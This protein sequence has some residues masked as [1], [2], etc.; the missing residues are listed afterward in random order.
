MARMLEQQGIRLHIVQAIGG[1]VEA[2]YF[3]R[4]E[5]GFRRLGFD[6]MAVVNGQQ[7]EFRQRQTEDRGGHYRA[8][9]LRPPHRAQPD[10]RQRGRE[11]HVQPQ[12]PGSRRVEQGAAK[13][14]GPPRV[15]VGE[16]QH[17]RPRGGSLDRFAR[18]RKTWI[19]VAVGGQHT[20]K[21]VLSACR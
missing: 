8:L 3:C 11:L 7:A 17:A 2:C 1:R 14:G 10:F 20:V 12:M 21:V 19:V 4:H 15:G 6:E 9:E 18:R 13:R 16:N 5:M